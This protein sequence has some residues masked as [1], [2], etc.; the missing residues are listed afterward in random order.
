[1]E[2]ELLKSRGEFRLKAGLLQELRDTIQE[3]IRKAFDSFNKVREKWDEIGDVPGNNYKEVH[4]EYY[5]LRDE[6]FYN[7]NIYK[8]LQENDLQVNHKMKKTEK[9]KKLGEIEDIKEKEKAARNLQKQWMD[10]VL[11]KRT[12]KEMGRFFLQSNSPC[13]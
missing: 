8:Q 2:S 10:M 3:N 9:A 4:D 12:Y 11:L 6:F 7:I 5:R 1:M 13:I